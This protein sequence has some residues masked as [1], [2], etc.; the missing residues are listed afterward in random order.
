MIELCH[1]ANFAVLVGEPIEA[2]ETSAGLRR[3][4]PIVG[5]E[6]TGPHLQGRVLAGG[7]DFQ[8]LR[9]NGVAELH[10]R[11]VIECQDGERI[12][13]ENCGLRHG[14]PEAMERLRRGEPVDPALIYF[15][16]TPRFETGAKKYSWLR[17][18]VF[19][20]SGVRRPNSVELS[21][22]QVL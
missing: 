16:T 7:A 13:V 2:G 12:Y 22:Y 19:T 4:I 9:P 18:Y 1:V 14:P 11:Y 10:A 5:G 21:V 3:V 8:I 20:A 17:D 15:R 6:V